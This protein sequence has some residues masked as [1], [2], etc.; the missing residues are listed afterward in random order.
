MNSCNA[1]IC[2]VK[3]ILYIKAKQIDFM[4]EWMYLPWTPAA[5]N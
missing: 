3:F 5:P 4:F 1:I 2:F